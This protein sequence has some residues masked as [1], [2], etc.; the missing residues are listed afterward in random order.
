MSIIAKFLLSKGT[1]AK[2]YFYTAERQVSNLGHTASKATSATTKPQVTIKSTSATTKPQVTIKPKPQ[3][4]IKSKPAKNVTREGHTSV[5][6]TDILAEQNKAI[7]EQSNGTLHRF[8]IGRIS[9]VN[10]L[11]K[12]FKELMNEGQLNLEK[13]QAIEKLF[14]ENTGIKLYCP[15]NSVE[16]AFVSSVIGIID[17]VNDGT[18][19]KEIKHI[20]IGH[21]VGSSLNPRTWKMSGISVKDGKDIE[22]FDFVNKL[23]LPK[24]EPVLVLCCEDGKK[25]VPNRPGIGMQVDLCLSNLGGF[26]R[27]SRAL[28]G[29]GKIV[30]SGENKICGHYT[31]IDKSAG[32]GLVY[33]D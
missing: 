23:K 17:A 10:P 25:S 7:I 19:P 3:V 18:F 13:A 28:M 29:P 26:D 33:Y 16:G 6:G 22:I 15:S 32:G 24:N 11:Y 8:T 20:L 30:R 1:T 27:V 12:Q 14:F 31:L 2:K 9:E 5:S 21:G 4:T